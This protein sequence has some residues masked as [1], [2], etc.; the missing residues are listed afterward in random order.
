VF[1]AFTTGSASL[2]SCCVGLDAT[3]LASGATYAAKTYTFDQAA[4]Y[5]A[6][7]I[8]VKP[9]NVT[10][11]VDAGATQDV[12]SGDAVDLTGSASDPDGTISSTVWSFPDSST[13]PA[14]LGSA[15]TITNSTNLTTATFTASAPGKYTVRLTVTDNSGGVTT[16]DV[17]IWACTT[18]ARIIEEVSAGGWTLYG[19]VASIIAGLADG[20]NTTGMQSVNNPAPDT[21]VGKLA[22]MPAG[23]K[24]INYA[25][26]LDA[27]GSG[28]YTI[29]L[30]QASTTIAARTISGVSTSI[31]TGTIDLSTAELA[32]ITDSHE[33]TI[34]IAAS[35]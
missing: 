27:S 5:G 35:A 34:T 31:V 24:T 1:D 2:S 33:L 32:A 6:W 9:A 11:T 7:A 15:P 3:G 26:Q 19:A 22:P 30:K 25:L 13:Y 16:D 10:P 12:M 4:Q 23:A 17:V 21:Y 28:A 14:S 18:T 29:T 8:V 20:S